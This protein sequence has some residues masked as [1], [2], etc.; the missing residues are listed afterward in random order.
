MKLNINPSS[1]MSKPDSPLGSVEDRLIRIPK[2]LRGKLGYKTGLFLSLKSKL[3]NPI[4]LQIM[5]A[6][7][8]DADADMES[9]WV[10]NETIKILDVQNM[11]TLKPAED[12][13]I[14]CDPEFFLVDYDVKRMITASHFFYR[15]GELGSDLGL[16]ELRPRPSSN[17]D[18]LTDNIRVLIAKADTVLKSRT[19]F[20]N[21]NLKMV[22]ASCYGDQIGGYATAG[23]HV[24]F[25]L[26]ENILN[27]SEQS[28]N[29]L[30]RMTWILDYYVG[31]LS[32]LPEREIDAIRRTMGRSQYGKPS[33]FRSDGHTLEYRVPGGHLLRH[34][35][36]TKALLSLSKVVMKDMMTRFSAYSDGFKKPLLFRKYDDLKIFYPNLPDR[37]LLWRAM[38]SPIPMDAMRMYPSI[39]TDITKMVGYEEQKQTIKEYTQYMEEVYVRNAMF[40]ERMASNWGIK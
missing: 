20:A 5:P 10:S 12:I 26:P 11:P 17:I 39:I 25:G 34:P 2:G 37:E 29:L 19:V 32:V 21:R 30:V 16:A 28:Y 9:A 22:A 36:L 13:L 33:D 24:H 1:E 4:V 3:G 38:T 14:G 31:V 18:Q 27:K 6:F 23:F 35:V 7:K 8:A 40:D 15:W